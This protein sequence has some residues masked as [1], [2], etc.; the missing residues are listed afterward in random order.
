L[1]KINKP[2]KNLQMK[3]LNNWIKTA[4]LSTIIIWCVLIVLTAIFIIPW[5][6]SKCSTQI[7][8]WWT[9]LKTYLGLVKDGGGSL[10]ESGGKLSYNTNSTKA[11]DV[12]PTK[13]T[14]LLGNYT[15]QQAVADAGTIAIYAQNY[16]WEDKLMFHETPFQVAANILGNPKMNTAKNSFLNEVFKLKYG[17]PIAEYKHWFATELNADGIAAMKIYIYGTPKNT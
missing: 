6:W 3:K 16:N 7:K 17:S 9:K 11:K 14:L 2:L 5:L 12:D 8:I 4:E 1:I 13:P 10:K 15:Y